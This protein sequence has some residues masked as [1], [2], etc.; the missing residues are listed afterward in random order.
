MIKKKKGKKINGIKVLGNDSKLK[1]F[2]KKKSQSLLLLVISK[3]ENQ[4]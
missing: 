3:K 4:F 1:K 2:S